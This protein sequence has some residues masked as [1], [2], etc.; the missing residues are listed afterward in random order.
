MKTHFSLIQHRIAFRAGLTLL[1]MCGPLAAATLTWDADPV[2]TG[3]Q[4]DPG[5]WNASSATWNDGAAIWN[6]ANPDSAIFGAGTGAAGTVSLALPVTVA[7]ITFNTPGSGSYVISGGAGLSTLTFAGT[8]SALVANA[9]A[10][11][12]APISAASS[13][14]LSKSGPGTLTL[15]PAAA[16]TF[17]QIQNNSKGLLVLG[18]TGTHTLEG[19]NNALRNVQQSGTWNG[20]DPLNGEIRITSGVWN[21]ANLSTNSSSASFRGTLRVAG[22]ELNVT[23]SG[24]FVGS[25]NSEAAIIVEG[26]TMRVQA[27]RFTPGSDGRG[28]ATVSVSDGILDIYSTTYGCTL[29]STSSSLWTQTGG[30]TRVGVSGAGSKKDLVIGG[31]TADVK[32]AYTLSG[33]SLTVFATLRAGTTAATT[34]LNN[35]NFNGGVL[36]AAAIDVTH[37]TRS[38]SL[39]DPVLDGIEPGVFASRG[40]TLAPGGPDIPG[41]TSINGSYLETSAS[42]VA[43]DIGG[44]SAAT[45]FQH[46]TGS[47]HDLLTITGNAALAGNL[48]VRLL[49]GF[50][51]APSDTFTVVTVGGALSGS[52]DNAPVNGR[53][54]TASGTG[55]FLVTLSG[56]NVVL[57]DYVQFL[58]IDIVSQPVSLAVFAG[59]PAGLAINVNSNSTT[60]YQWHKDGL[61]LPGANAATYSLSATQVSDAGVYTVVATNAVGSVTSQP[62]RLLVAPSWSSPIAFRYDMDAAPVTGTNNVPDSTGLTQ[63]TLVNSPA[64][65]LT[66]GPIAAT[67]N[68]WDFRDTTSYIRVAANDVT[69]SLGDISKTSGLT[70]AFWVNAT[71]PPTNT[72]MAGL[73]GTIDLNVSGTGVLKFNFG[74]GSNIPQFGLTTPG[75]TLNGTWKHLVATVDFTTG[76]NNA[77]LYVNGSQTAVDSQL[78]QSSFTSGSNFMIAARDNGS[79]QAKGQLDQF[80]VFTRALSPS[81]VT[82]LYAGNIANY[83]PDLV[84]AARDSSIIAPANGTTLLALAGDDGF[85][86]SPGA[87]S[88]VWSLVSGPG[89]VSFSTPSTN[90]TDA[91]FSALGTYVVRVTA[92]DGQLASTRDITVRVVENQVPNVY[93]GAYIRSANTGATVS[94]TGGATDDGLPHDPGALAYQWT[95]TSG[96]A[97]TFGTPTERN[98]TV[99]LPSAP[100][101]HIFRLSVSDG[102]LTSYKEITITAAANLAP[103]V[104]VT[105]TAPIVIW[106]ESGPNL[107]PLVASATDDGFPAS[108]GSLTY[109]WSKLSGPGTVTFASPGSASTNA[110]FSAPGLYQLSASVSD[111]ALSTSADIWINVLPPGSGLLGDAPVLEVFTPTPPP[112]EHPRIFFTDADRPAMLARAANVPSVIAG[113]ASLRSHIAGNLDN[114][115]TPVGKAFLAAKAGNVGYSMRD[116]IEA[117]SPLYDN[118]AGARGG[119]YSAMASACFV[120]WLDQ[121]NPARLTDLATAVATIARQHAT[122]YVP[123]PNTADMGY[124]IYA[125]LGFC[126]DLMYDWMTEEQRGTTRSLLSAMTYSRRTLVWNERDTAF[127]TNWR[128]FH[129]HIVTAGLAIEGEEGYDAAAMADI[130]W[131]LKRFCSKWGM[132]PEGFSREGPGYFGFGMT[133]GATAAYSLSRRGENLFV[134]T[135]LGRGVQEYFYQLAPD[136]SGRMTGHND[137]QGWGNGSGQASYYD[138]VKAVYP[139]DPVVDL[140]HRK[141][142]E[143]MKSATATELSQP[144]IR[145]IFGR[146]L[147]PGNDSF[148][149]VA[150]AKN[151]PVALF[152]PQ[153]GLGVARSGWDSDALRLDFDSRPDL[154]D[155]GHVHSDRNSFYLAGSG[156]DWIT[157]SGYHNEENDSHSTVLID[158]LGLAGS[159]LKPKWPAL[160]GKFVESTHTPLLTLFA[161]DAKAAYWYSWNSSTTFSYNNSSHGLPTPYRWAD[162]FPPG[163]HPPTATS[164]NNLWAGKFVHAEADPANPTQLALYNPVEKAFRTSLMVRGDGANAQPYVL[165]FDDIQKDSLPR[166]YQWSAAVGGE[167]GNMMVQP[168][169][170]SNQAILY[171]TDDAASGSALPRLLVRVLGSNGSGPPIGVVDTNVA[172]DPIPRLV[173][174]RENVVAPDFK[175]LLFPHRDGASLPAT[176][177]NGNVITIQQGGAVDT[178]TLGAGADGRTRVVSFTR[179]GG[180]P[181]VITVPPTVEVLANEIGDTGLSYATVNFAPSALDSAGQAL[182]VDVLPASGTRFRA[183]RTEVRVA[184]TDSAGRVS[185]RTFDVVVAPPAPA[186][187]IGSIVNTSSSGTNSIGLSWTSGGAESHVV[188]RST[189]PGGPYTPIASGITGTSYTVSGLGSGPYYYVVTA[190]AGGA[191]SADSNE[192]AFTSVPAPWTGADIGNVVLAG[193]SALQ[194]GVFTITAAGADIWSGADAFHFVSRPWTGDGLLT[195]R[196]LSLGNTNGSAKAGVMFRENTTAGSRYAATLITPTSG[197]SQQARATDGS[198]TSSV[199]LS[200]RAA[201]Q[202]LRLL[203]QGNGFTTFAS[204]DGVTWTQIGSTTVNMN[205]TLL[206]GLAVTSHNISTTTAA[207]F[208]N[209]RFVGPPTAP[210]GLTA[211]GTPSTVLL[212]WTPAADADFYTIRRATS[213]SGPFTTVATAPTASYDDTGLPNGTPHY[214]TVSSTNALGESPLSA[215]VSATPQENFTSWKIAQ[216][217]PADAPTTMLRPDGV[218][219]LLAYALNLPL[220]GALPGP[221]LQGDQMAFTFL[222]ARAD[223]IYEVIGSDD[224]NEW[225]VI[226]T[227]PGTVGQVVTVVDTNPATPR[228]FI[229]LRVSQ[230]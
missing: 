17:G 109:A 70:V 89:T 176:T 57:S 94:L 67:G 43:I 131:A 147:L 56:N 134:T 200:G 157:D 4:D 189:T 112:Y 55:S 150:A 183:G 174:T 40:G 19:P 177:F 66:S 48:A 77:R 170:T 148:A 223:V 8:S 22:G 119:L 75:S 111:G 21:L 172:G 76:T 11:I 6:S 171:R 108:P 104:S 210:N 227:D 117:G 225:T 162:F 201:P 51:P 106:H 102:Q 194:D 187:A 79:G 178:L 100:G 41:K 68:A 132:T 122:W 3:N 31:S 192:V 198:T 116:V 91:T 87:V 72:R 173:I 139:T 142:M 1:V 206:A 33:G 216:G 5:V 49:P 127:S 71:N 133:N 86:A 98:T 124:D 197:A 25:T 130:K 163:F 193:G 84:A 99:S 64:P 190:F 30:S 214:Y 203:R 226:A 212:G 186:L 220:H 32:T 28:P 182:A 164:G 52:F 107:A 123:K 12:T 224:L 20:V 103:A 78:I 80:T 54:L 213:S 45:A 136:N 228:R 7:G 141:S 18:G 144:L 138:V 184:A 185:T 118:M 180:T 38:S 230:R 143:A 149:A 105:S 140:V 63:G 160:P 222:R 181:P 113:V 92:S 167:G 207:R 146:A 218:A 101:S 221:T 65:L 23:A 69:R 90:V 29:G 211:T 191:G 209:V 58:P 60:S 37:L 46:A 10:G 135:Y 215:V 204:P 24:R 151:L 2:L 62:A 202:W 195:A 35:F 114:S 15:A 188:K 137:A 9:D 74:N 158:N 34:G 125:E 96:P 44:V 199:S 27:D 50:I 88:Y 121:N 169:A 179:N 155:I 120:A 153:R 161:G 110:T 13:H 217:F 128:T 39:T 159:S 61:A 97:V 175:V 85:P 26:G 73:G 145:A 82:Q 219:I 42:T 36:T 81:E 14:V 156:R 205:A 129:D 16:S 229:R 59:Q 95:Q 47:Y 165:V 154:I 168:G 166:Q 126:Y 196:V 83:P 53:V 208:D 93:V 115:N 152:S